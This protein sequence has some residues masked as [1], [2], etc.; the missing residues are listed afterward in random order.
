MTDKPKP[1]RRWLQFSLRTMMLVVT[2]F[3][4]WLGITAKRARDQKQTVEAI[5]DLGGTVFYDFHYYEHE[6]DGQTAIDSSRDP[7]SPRW[8]RDW[9]GLDL[10]HRVRYVRAVKLLQI[11]QPR[12]GI[13]LLGPVPQATQFS[14]RIDEHMVHLA[15][16]H[17]LETLDLSH[18][19]ITDANLVH[20]ESLTNLKLLF[21][22]H[23][24]VTDEGVERFQR[25]LPNCK[26]SH[27]QGRWLHIKGL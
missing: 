4:V 11:P 20:L 23:T 21:L 16:L 6:S 26:I 8:L 14:K 10:F 15:A 22:M 7:S 27:Y 24:G 17:D 19:S 12:I 5:Q 1:K 25:A 2:V 18:S 3:C 9:L 13:D